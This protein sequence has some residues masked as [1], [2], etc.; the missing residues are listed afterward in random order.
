MGNR[1][2]ISYDNRSR[3]VGSRAKTQAKKTTGGAPVT[4]RSKNARSS[5]LYPQQK[6][7]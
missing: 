6:K 5:F 3:G 7:K 2:A 1:F 4:F